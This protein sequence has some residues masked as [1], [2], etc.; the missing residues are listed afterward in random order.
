MC[1]STKTHLSLK[2]LPRV[3]RNFHAIRPIRLSCL[4]PPI[5]WTEVLFS[6]RR[7]F[8]VT[9]LRVP[10][11]LRYKGRLVSIQKPGT[12]QAAHLC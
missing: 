4:S 10:Y 12:Q 7:N 1:E 11:E 8:P 2:Q 5:E 9:T 3:G 6:P